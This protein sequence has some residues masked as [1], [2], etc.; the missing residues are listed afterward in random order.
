MV[1]DAA[2]IRLNTDGHAYR[3]LARVTRREI[4]SA[5]ARTRPVGAIDLVGD[6]A[7]PIAYDILS[8]AL[9]DARAKLAQRSCDRPPFLSSARRTDAP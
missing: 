8:G 6:L 2:W 3:V 9:R 1:L 5:L 4:E 7:T